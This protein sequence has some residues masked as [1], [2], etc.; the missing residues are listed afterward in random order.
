MVSLAFFYACYLEQ[1]GQNGS[2]SRT[3]PLFYSS[4]YVYEN[5]GV[6][7]AFE[8]VPLPSRHA[9]FFLSDGVF[10]QL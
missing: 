6:A 1:L 3:P 10:N 9:K 4:R 5:E 7:R 8:T 2:M